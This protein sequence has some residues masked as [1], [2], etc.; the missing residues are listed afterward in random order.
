MAAAVL[1]GLYAV[2]VSMCMSV[3]E[4][5]E[6]ERGI[7][8]QRVQGWLQSAAS[9]A[10]ATAPRGPTTMT[11]PREAAT[12]KPSVGSRRWWLGVV[13]VFAS[14]TNGGVLAWP[15]MAGGAR[16][17]LRVPIILWYMHDNIVHESVARHL[18]L[19]LR[20][21]NVLIQERTLQQFE[22]QMGNVRT[23]VAVPLL[24]V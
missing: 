1:L 12:S 10:A 5:K 19:Q 24:H 16:G 23:Y 22:S 21:G 4:E 8:L 11:A 13:A 9:T 14:R 6:R 7:L 17:N 18:L 20:C 2:S 3:E 15:G